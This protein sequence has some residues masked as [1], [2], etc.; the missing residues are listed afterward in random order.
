MLR[1]L[2]GIM[3]ALMLAMSVTFSAS[4]AG[5]TQDGLNVTA[6]PSKQEYTGDEIITLTLTVKNGGEDAVSSV[7]L[8]NEVPDGYQLVA[9]S[10]AVRQVGTL[11]AGAEAVLTSRFQK[12][13]VPVTG[14]NT[15]IALLF[16]L[17]AGSFVLMMVLGRRFRRA[18]AFGLVLVLLLTSF[19][20]VGFE[21]ASAASKTIR[22]TTPVLVD[23]DELDLNSSVSYSTD[24]P[25]GTVHGYINDALTGDPLSG[26]T[27]TFYP[28]A[29]NPNN[30]TNAA[31]VT[32]TTDSNGYYSVSLPVGD[33]TAVMTLP[34]YAP[35]N[36]NVESQINDN[37]NQNG[38]LSPLQAEGQYRIVLSWASSPRD[39]D[40]HLSGTL[41]NGSNIHV[42]YSNKKANVNG[43]KL[44]E[45]DI[46]DTSSYGP[47]TVT[48]YK[49]ELGNFR[50][51]I[52]DYTNRNNSSTDAMAKSNATVTVYRGNTQV[53]L[54]KVPNQPGTLW[55]VFEINNGSLV[56]V[57]TMSYHSSPSSIRSGEMNEKTLEYHVDDKDYN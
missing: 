41:S 53:A 50:Y 33:Y 23:E 57:N 52:H 35:G 3:L 30:A 20:A 26:V 4:A 28:G 6:V 25:M 15:P 34:G 51:S 13:V 54:F 45:L 2:F 38:V 21:T 46:D 24:E 1:K 56:P 12:A 47:E 27:I 29:N 22:L 37:E 44:A 18:G 17:M 19:G 43:E 55:T 5:V 39:L 9:G 10:A 8:T 36:M 48:I 49:P 42:Y 32:V 40:S 11:N 16:A 31:P 7:V 14:D